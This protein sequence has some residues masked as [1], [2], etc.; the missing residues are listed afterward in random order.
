M[1]TLKDQI[2]QD[3]ITTMK[4]GDK[5]KLGVLRMLSAALKQKEV[6]ER[7]ELEDGHVL[8]ILNKMIKQRRD[9]ISQ[10]EKAARQDLIDQEKFEISILE[11]YLPEQMSNDEIT[12]AVQAEIKT[13]GAET[14]KDIGKVMGPLKGKLAGKADMGKVSKIVRESL[15]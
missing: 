15:G 6:D 5:P 12:A 14:M 10:F 9:S 7:I 4:A 11:I 1:T 13:V 2:K 3:T 8:A